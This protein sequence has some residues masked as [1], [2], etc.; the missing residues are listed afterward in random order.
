MAIYLGQ[1]QLTGVTNV[2]LGSTAQ[3]VYLGSTLIYPQNVTYTLS[4]ASVSYSSGSQINAGGTNY[5]TITANVYTYVNG[6]YV[7]SAANQTLSV[8]KVSGSGFTTSAGTY[9]LADNRSNVTGSTRSATYYATYDNITAGTFTVTQLYN[10]TT[11]SST[12]TAI[13]VVDDECESV[14]TINMSHSGGYVDNVYLQ[15]TYDD[16][17]VYTSGYEEYIGTHTEPCDPEN[18]ISPDTYSVP[19]GTNWMSVDAYGNLYV[20]ANTSTTNSRQATVTCYYS[21]LGV[22]ANTTFTL[23]QY[24]ASVRYEYQYIISEAE[25]QPTNEFE[26]YDDYVVYNDIQLSAIRRYGY[27]SDGYY[28]VTQTTLWNTDDNDVYVELTG[29]NASRFELFDVNEVSQGTSAVFNWEN[30]TGRV[31]ITP[32]QPNMSDEVITATLVVHF[33]DTSRELE[34][35]QQMR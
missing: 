14:S 35:I 30:R 8:H 32:T 12:L 20:S 2:T 9:I 24:D 21:E 15:L 19:S 10:Y 5:A 3:T 34:V 4:A 7:S 29:P 23:Y 18:P 26:A 25:M 22:T 33:F 1:T 27:Y 28:H 17:L 11:T 6:T 13:S 16:T 31:L